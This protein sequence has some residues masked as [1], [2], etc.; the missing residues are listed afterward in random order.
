MQWR[1]WKRDRKDAEGFIQTTWVVRSRSDERNAVSRDVNDILDAN[2]FG[3][4][5]V[6]KRWFPLDKTNELI[7][8]YDKD[9]PLRFYSR[10]FLFS[11]EARIRFVEGDISKHFSE[12]LI[13]DSL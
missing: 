5:R 9:Y 11:D 1:H 10:E 8:T 2:R 12:K 6:E 3:L 13:A 4:S 7:A